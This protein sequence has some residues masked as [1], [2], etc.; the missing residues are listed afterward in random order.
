MWKQIY[1]MT[2]YIFT[3][4][5]IF[6]FFVD[7]MWDIEYDNASETYEDGNPT[8][9]GIVFTMIFNAFVWMHIFNE[10]N[11]RKVGASQYK[12]FKGLIYNWM[13]LV[14]FCGI[15][16]LQYFFV[17]KGGEAMQTVPLTAK[18]HASCIIWVQLLSW[19]S[20]SSN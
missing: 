20:Q 14:V 16:A 1:G 9:K 7:N 17:Q 12:M 6:Y 3:I 18:E 13:F 2:L 10:F 8:P 5:T 4:S 15:M 11:C 19:C